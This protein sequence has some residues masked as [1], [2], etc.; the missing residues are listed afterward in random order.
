[1][2][3]EWREGPPTFKAVTGACN[4]CRG[5]GWADLYAPHTLRAEALLARNR[6]GSRYTDH[7]D[8]RRVRGQ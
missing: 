7:R 3:W 6:H 4:V 5:E 2:A 1:M 8:G